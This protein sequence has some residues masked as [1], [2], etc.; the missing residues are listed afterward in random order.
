MSVQRISNSNFLSTPVTSINGY[1]VD[2]TSTGTTASTTAASN[3]DVDIFPVNKFIKP[4]NV[5]YDGQTILYVN[6]VNTT[7]STSQGQ[8]FDATT[9]SP[10]GGWSYNFQSYN[11]YNGSVAYS[12]LISTQTS[13]YQNLTNSSGANI[14]YAL[15]F[16]LS[17]Q[18]FLDL[19]Q[20][21]DI[22]GPVSRTGVPLTPIIL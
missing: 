16:G 4:V 7:Q 12:S 11:M 17:G 14:F 10:P 15:T 19:L 6:S 2:V 13:L 18:P 1:T 3:A 20:P 8:Y 5:T 9:S 22:W 21:I